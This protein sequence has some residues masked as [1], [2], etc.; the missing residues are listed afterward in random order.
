MSGIVTRAEKELHEIARQLRL[1]NR[2]EAFR[3][4]NEYNSEE[5]RQEIDRIIR[6]TELEG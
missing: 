2:L 6:L 1:A 5:N 3:L 4:R